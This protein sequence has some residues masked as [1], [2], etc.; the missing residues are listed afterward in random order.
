MADGSG[1]ER[2][3]T[4]HP[5]IELILDEVEE[6]DAVLDIGC[7]QHTAEKE[8]SGD[9]HWLHGELCDVTDDVLGLDYLDEEV[10]KLN[11]RGYD[12][13]SANAEAFELDQRFDVVTAGELIEHLANPG[14]FMDRVHEH[15]AAD[16][17]FVL[18]TPNPWYVRRFVEAFLMGEVAVNPEHTCWFDKKTLDE[19]LTRAGFELETFRYVKAPQFKR[20]LS[21]ENIDAVM[22]RA[23][24]RIWFDTLTGHSIFAVATTA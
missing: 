8:E 10:E 1:G 2:I 22:T 19:T 11:E 3:I 6:G 4:H 7:V 24:R 21:L 20:T 16:G 23:V 13:V 18:T 14:L 12:V 17:K 5:R 9:E 15:L